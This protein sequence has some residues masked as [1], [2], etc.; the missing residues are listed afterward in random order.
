MAL[1][2]LPIGRIRSRALVEAPSKRS[3]MRSDVKYFMLQ[4]TSERTSHHGVPGIDRSVAGDS[5]PNR[6]VGI[7]AAF[8]IE[9]RLVAICSIFSG[10]GSCVPC[11]RIDN[12]SFVRN[13]FYLDYSQPID[14]SE[15]EATVRKIREITDISERRYAATDRVASELAR[16]AGRAA[17]DDSGID[18]ESLDVLIVAHNFGDVREVGGHSDTVPTLAARVKE[19]LGIRNPHCVASDLPFGCAGWVQGVIHADYFLR[20]GDARRALVI[21]AETLSRVCDPHDRDS[22]IYADGA[23][24]VVMEGVE[25]PRPVGILS[26]ATRSDTTDTARLL[27]MGPSYAEND[28][29]R[30]LYLKMRGRELY[31]YAVKTVPEVVSLSLSRAGIALTEVDRILIH[32]ANAKLD[33][34]ILRRLFRKH[35]LP[36]PDEDVMPMT[37]SWLG[38]SSVATVPTLFDLVRKGEVEAPDFDAGDIVVFAAVG[39]GMNANSLVYRFPTRAR[40]EEPGSRA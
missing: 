10:T 26:H 31:E 30:G 36:V 25:T 15:N 12:Q 1:R 37:I 39:A 38:N 28:E 11:R 35:E 14:S 22:M 33:A 27:W 4:S 29:D 34:A 24:A 23:G 32:Q 9:R 13:E 17:L 21:G 6:Y 19:A 8:P 40:S 5:N 3:Q 7:W 18:P 2:F 16:E 20:S